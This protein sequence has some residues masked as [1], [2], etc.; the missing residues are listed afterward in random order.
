MEAIAG[1]REQVIVF[2]K[3][4]DQASPSYLQMMKALAGAQRALDDSR[5]ILGAS[6]D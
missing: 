5:R 3:Q 4:G 6:H 2:K 1:M